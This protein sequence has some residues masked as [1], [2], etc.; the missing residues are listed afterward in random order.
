[1]SVGQRKAFISSTS[2][3]LLEH[4]KQ[5]AE[6][7][8]RLGYWPI[9]ME[10]WPAQDADAET[11]CLRKVDG[12][13]LF[14][15]VYAFRY[16]WT[17]PGYEVSISELEYERA[18]AKG[19]PRLLFFA[20]D[21]HPWPPKMVDK[22]EAG[23]KLDAFKQR[24]GGERVGSFFTTEK[25]LRGLVMQALAEREKPAVTDFRSL[26]THIPSA[27]TPYIAHPYVLMQSRRLVGRESELSLLTD[28][29]AKPG[30]TV[31]QNPILSFIAIGGMG[32]SALTWH[33]FN[34]IAA[35]EM[36]PLAGRLWWSFYESNAGFDQF[37]LHALA[38]CTNRTREDIGK[39]DLS[40]QTDQLWQALNAQPFLIVLDGLERILTAYNRLDAPR[41][42]DDDLDEAT[43]NH[44][45]DAHGLP[46]G[47]GETYLARHKLRT[48]TDLRAGRFLRQL[49]TLQHSRILISSRLY[50]AELQTR[51]AHPIPGCFVWLQS[52]LAPNDA[53]AL[54]RE[55][56]VSGAREQLLPLFQSI[57]FHPLLIQALAGEVAAWRPDP[58]NFDA[59]QRAHPGLQPA[60][61]LDLRQRQSHILAHALANLGTAQRKVLHTLA[62][63][64][65]PTGYDT[66][67]AL[68]VGE[69]NPCPDETALDRC[70][71]EL[72]D[73]GLVGW[74]RR[75]NRYDL[76]PIVRGVVWGRLGADEKQTVLLNLE[77]Y[78]AAQP[79]VEDWKKVESIAELEPAIELYDKLIGL[80]SYQQAR[81]LFQDRLEQS[82]LH[83]LS[84]AHLR[85]SL[86]LALFPLC[87]D[88][89]VPPLPSLNHAQE[90]VWA[91][92]ALAQAYQITGFPEN[93]AVLFRRAIEISE[94]NDSNRAV[95]LC[96]LTA[97]QR[98]SGRLHSSECSASQ[99]LKLAADRR[100]VNISRYRLGNVFTIRGEVDRASSYLKDAAQFF[101]KIRNRQSEGLC[102][103]YR[104]ELALYQGQFTQAHELA[105]DAER[106]A[107]V[108]RAERD[109]IRTARLQGTA[110]LQ[111]DEFATADE[112]LHRALQR[113]RAIDYAE[114]ELPTL[115]ALAELRRRQGNPAAAREFLDQVWEPAERG[116]YPLFHADALNVL[117][118]IERDA[119]NTEQAIAAAT[120]AY[121]KSWC[122]G[123]PYAYHWGLTAARKHLQELGAP[124]PNLPP[125]D[126]S[127][128]EPMPEVD[129]TPVLNTECPG[130]L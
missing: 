42:L 118:Q 97:T 130:E 57:N 107:S 67:R 114:E 33:F 85:K 76:H 7:C 6:A 71:G 47:A 19:I 95:V 80:G 88:A 86:L 3:D 89:Q 121:Q 113:A 25:D 127:K 122:D 8:Q 18:K 69:G 60:A 115:V 15:G 13:E 120:Q 94:E 117:A 48:C 98:L 64:R 66:L 68:L 99:A 34:Y 17:P 82:T 87:S 37:V 16:G 106:L 9:G 108:E 75:A 119:G 56:G 61:H 101:N 23:T 5:V 36:R 32:K 45:A 91:L 44:I 4:R 53:L 31:Y 1:M 100:R 129:L 83:R 124:E 21:N 38:Y 41:M 63:F 72:E 81:K 62:G 70:L 123:P 43:A 11:V 116:P 125:F 39:L 40:T 104:A 27:P 90:Q 22:G 73:R 49:A 54:W 58:G 109:F 96:N 79:M 20:D 14:I 12:C 84:S 77:A 65:M 126:P 10:T 59:W 52:G 26:A 28:W 55:L 102:L 128:H 50:P 112:R 92:N 93:A 29:V 24:V 74:E 111:L 110:A 46:T 51:T 78:F 105:K 103:A 30:S 2:I 35:N